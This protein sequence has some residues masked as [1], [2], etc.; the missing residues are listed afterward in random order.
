[1]YRLIEFLRKVYVFLLFI[2][3]ECGAIYIYVSAD[4]YARAKMLS[5]QS[6]VVGSID[7][8]MRGMVDYFYLKGENR[9][10]LER[11]AE[12]EQRLAGVEMARQDSLM[13]A[14][15]YYDDVAKVSYQSA[16]VVSNT[17]NR[18]HNYMVINQGVE[19]GVRTGMGVVTPQHEMVG[20]VME[21]TD[22]YSVVMSTLNTRFRTSGKIE[23]D[24]YAGYV[25]WEGSDRYKMRMKDLSKYANAQIGSRVETTSFSQI[26][27]AGVS[28]GQIVDIEYDQQTLSYNLEIELAA[29]ISRV[30]RVLVVN[31][32]V[33]AGAEELINRVDRN[34]EG[35]GI[36]PEM[37]DY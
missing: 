36:Y 14:S 30:Y 12:L 22:H 16:Y 10:L 1:M 6:S 5:I 35:V 28:I 21:A 2:V 23:D 25:F 15:S 18:K 37:R 29:D 9:E 7:Y 3:L 11:V 13:V 24:G 20:V 19:H 32:N 4:S 31:Y 33:N 17:I 27:P 34:F 26:F 8:F